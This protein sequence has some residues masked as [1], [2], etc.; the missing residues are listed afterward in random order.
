MR[1]LG[2][3]G[4]GLGGVAPDVDEAA[5]DEKLRTSPF[6]GLFVSCPIHGYFM[7]YIAANQL[8]IH[9]ESTRTSDSKERLIIANKI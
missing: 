5:V 6:L 3:D 7:P 9:T 1:G 2:R 8:E 4:L